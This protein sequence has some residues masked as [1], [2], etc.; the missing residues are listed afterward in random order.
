MP[1]GSYRMNKKKPS[2]FFRWLLC[3]AINR[4]K[5]VIMNYRKEM[6]EQ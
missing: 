4:H 3:F 1:E 5:Y 6:E 2:K